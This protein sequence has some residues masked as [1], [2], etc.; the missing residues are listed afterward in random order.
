VIVSSERAEQSTAKANRALAHFRIHYAIGSAD[1]A[2]GRLGWTT[3]AGEPTFQSHDAIL[4]LIAIAEEFSIARFVDVIETLL[5]SEPVVS[6]LWEAELDRSGDT[7]PKRNILWKKYL[8]VKIKDFPYNKDLQGFIQARNS[9]THGLGSLTR[10]Q[11]RSRATTAQEL[12][13]AGIRL[14]GDSLTIDASDVEACATTVKTFVGW[15]D[16]ATM[17]PAQ[18]I[19]GPPGATLASAQLENN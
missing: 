19:A 9:I 5:P 8:N 4:R 18:P 12:R 7:W 10:R 13:D 3:A 1:G 17:V 15:L 6:A 16:A 2:A 11:L 14:H